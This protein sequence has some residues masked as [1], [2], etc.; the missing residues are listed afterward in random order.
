[1]ALFMLKI[2]HFLFCL[3][4]TACH[5]KKIRKLYGADWWPTGRRWI[6]HKRSDRTGK[7]EIIWFSKDFKQQR[8]LHVDQ[9]ATFEKNTFNPVGRPIPPALSKRRHR[10]AVADKQRFFIQVFDTHSG[11]LLHALEE[12]VHQIPF[13]RA[14]GE[15]SAKKMLAMMQNHDALKSKPTMFRFPDY[16]PPILQLDY[17]VDDHLAVFGLLRP[18]RIKPDCSFDLDGEKVSLKG[19]PEDYISRILMQYNGFSYLNVYKDEEVFI[20]KILSAKLEETL[21]AFKKIGS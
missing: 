4:L 12:K 8:V 2:Q 3:I 15:E 18:G 13:D 17:T 6:A 16:L 5:S 20:Q 14:W 11:S 10:L 1:M 21:G 7:A 9:D 19:C